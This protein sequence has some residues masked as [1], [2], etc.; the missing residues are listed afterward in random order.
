MAACSRRV[1]WL[2]A[3]LNGLNPV[4]PFWQ[5]MVY[6]AAQLAKLEMSQ[7]KQP[8]WISNGKLQCTICALS[9]RWHAFTL[10]GAHFKPQ[11]TSA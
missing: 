3:V 10:G 2:A 9:C 7:C 1:R 5:A 11:L 8:Y 6:G 4:D